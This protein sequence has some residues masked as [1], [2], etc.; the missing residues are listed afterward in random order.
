MQL[1][2]KAKVKVVRQDADLLAQLFEYKMFL[3]AD[4]IEQAWAKRKTGFSEEEDSLLGV[5]ECFLLVLFLWV[6]TSNSFVLCMRC[7]LYC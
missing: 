4:F 7:Q 5:M 2:H 1:F 6:F 3:F